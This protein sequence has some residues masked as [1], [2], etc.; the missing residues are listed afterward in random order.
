L[1]LPLT[2]FNLL[3][4]PVLYFWGRPIFQSVVTYLA[5]IGTNPLVSPGSTGDFLLGCFQFSLWF[6]FLFAVDYVGWRLISY[7]VPRVVVFNRVIFKGR[8]EAEIA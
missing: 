3:L 6:I 4:F 7:R 2:I 5:R 8:N 1:L